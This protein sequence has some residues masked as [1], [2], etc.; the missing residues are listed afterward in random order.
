MAHRQGRLD[1]AYQGYLKLLKKKPNHGDGNYLLGTLLLGR[2]EH[3]KALT[4]L[5]RANTLLPTSP[6]V[7]CNLG[8]LYRAMGKHDEAE[9]AFRAALR[10]QPNLLE[11]LNNLAILLVDSGRP[12]E[13]EQLSRRCIA[14][15]GDA[16][17]FGLI[18]CASALSDQGRAEEALAMLNEVIAYPDANNTAWDNYL[19][20]LNYTPSVD[21]ERL[22]QEHCRW[23]KRF[24]KP[25]TLPKPET[26]TPI[27]L[28]Y[29]SPDLKSH[30]VGKLMEP[31]LQHHDQQRFEIY[32]YHDNQGHDELTKR[33]QQMGFH[34]RDVANLDNQQCAK[35]IAEDGIQI[36][37]ELS[38]HTAHNRLPML[39]ERVAPIQISYLGYCTTTGLQNMDYVITDHFFDPPGAEDGYSEKMLVLPRISF[40]YQSPEESATIAAPQD[41]PFTF[42]SFNALKKVSVEVIEAWAEILNGAPDSR[43]I[44]Q[45]AGLD[46][47]ALQQQLLQQFAEKGVAAE[48]IQFYGF[49]DYQT[50]LSLV[51]QCD[52]TLDPWPW[53]GHMTTLNIL[54][55]GVPMLT[56]RGGHRSGRMGAAI[57]QQIE[58]PLFIAESRDEYVQKAI[59]F[60]QQRDELNQ[61]R[62]Q[63]RQRM[64]SSSMMDGEGLAKAMEAA[65]LSTIA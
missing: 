47:V 19:T 37:V 48:R 56:L 18:Q 11:A 26:T 17:R 1:E 16:Q 50:H 15:G 2:G 14:L 43:L 30:P 6:M 22:Y 65:Y 46:E 34:W 7:K 25:H 24:E 41:G 52:L 32:I 60:S 10:F 58:Q 20:M 3:Q 63:L 64:A 55:M 57:L 39:A 59:A 62:P 4:H 42:G 51:A 31:L 5:Q 23:A 38:G 13:A 12:V 8:L 29:L 45:S 53:N 35:L 44:M 49:S 9:K 33:L 61:L 36:L 54:W 21:R 40:A 28:A 27:K